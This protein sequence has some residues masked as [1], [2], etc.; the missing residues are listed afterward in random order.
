MYLFYLAIATEGMTLYTGKYSKHCT[1]DKSICYN[2]ENYLLYNHTCL[3]QDTKNVKTNTR[4]VTLETL[5][6]VPGRPVNT[7]SHTLSTKQIAL[8][9]DADPFTE[10]CS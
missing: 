10:C 4:E 5:I 8:P 1:V 7:K 9:T 3:L 6:F 2:C